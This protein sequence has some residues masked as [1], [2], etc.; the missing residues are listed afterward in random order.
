MPDYLQ[1]PE[2]IFYYK[3]SSADSNDPSTIAICWGKNPKNNNE[4]TTK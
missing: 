2:N 4:K 1:H 3:D